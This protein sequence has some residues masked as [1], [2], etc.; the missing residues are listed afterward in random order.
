MPN[1]HLISFVDH[2]TLVSED[3]G[4]IASYLNDGKNA[5]FPDGVNVSF[6]EILSEDEIFVRTYERG[7]GYTNA[8]GTAMSASSLMYVLEKTDGKG[9]EKTLS[10]KNPGG[11]VK[12]IV[13]RKEDGNYFMSLIGNGTFVAKCTVSLD[14][15]LLGDFS[16]ATWEETGEQA[17]YEKFVK[18]IC[19]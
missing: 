12:T 7:V 6:V 4:R 15:A 10:V 14:E 1:P 19:E 17:S 9:F 16:A 5:L 2:E 18:K 11:M 13:H 3:L 8:C